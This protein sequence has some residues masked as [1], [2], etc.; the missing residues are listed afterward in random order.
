MQ[1]EDNLW[2]LVI[3]GILFELPVRL[4]NVYELI[5]F[6]K[7]STVNAFKAHG[8]V[9][10][11][12]ADSVTES[13]SAIRTVR[14]FSGEKRQIDEGSSL[15]L[16]DGFILSWWKQSKGSELSLDC[17][18]IYRIY[19]YINFRKTGDIC[20]EDVD[21]SYPVRPDVEILRG[22]NL[23]LKCG[24]VTALVGPSGAG[25]STVV[26]LLARFYEL[27]KILLM[28]SLM[29]M[30]PRMTD[31]SQGCQHL[32]SNATGYDT[33]VGE[34]G[35]LLSGGHADL[36]LLLMYTASIFPI[37]SRRTVATSALDTV[38]E[39]LVQ[40]ALDQLMKGRTT[41]VIAH[42][43]STVQNADQIALCSDGK[44][45]E[46]GTHLE[47]LGRKGQYASLVDTQRLAFE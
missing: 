44:I 7:R 22:L 18:F 38:S 47:L 27:E 14:S 39:R 30:Y 35:G 43:L 17:G 20:L 25:K 4:P 3:T 28:L 15:Y 21:F 24:T 32:I 29:N 45:A 11:S 19:I 10:A 42:R 5:Y 23:T 31:S 9:Q 46:L 41:L 16:L 6:H 40:E 2:F 8:L 37:C 13:F 36:N 34:R 26:Q 12:I 33:L 1:K